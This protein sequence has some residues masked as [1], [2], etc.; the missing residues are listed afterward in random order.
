MRMIVLVATAL[1][2]LSLALP[3]NAQTTSG[4]DK[5]VG[6]PGAV[7]K[8]PARPAGRYNPKEISIDRAVPDSKDGGKAGLPGSRR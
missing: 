4:T 7:Q 3:A 5:E 8:G 6:K 1:S 2:A